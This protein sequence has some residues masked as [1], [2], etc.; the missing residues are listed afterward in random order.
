MQLTINGTQKEFENPMTIEQ[1][2][3]RLNLSTE[4]GL[5]VALNYSVISRSSF[6]TTQIQDGDELE[7]IH[8]TSGG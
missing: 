7:I 4:D 6:K 1:M 8:A 2:L 5:A 3:K